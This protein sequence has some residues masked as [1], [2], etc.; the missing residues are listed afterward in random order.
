M[1]RSGEYV[2]VYDVAGPPYAFPIVLLHGTAWT[3]KMWVP[4][5]EALSE[6]FRVIAVDLP[7]H[8]VLRGE[9]F[10]LT[11][12][13]RI[14]MESLRQE[15]KEPG[16]L[17]G[18]SLGG[19]VA[20]GCVQEYAQDIAGLVL[21][22]CSIDYR[23]V[24]GFLS[25]LDSALVTRLFSEQRLTRMQERTLRSKFSERVIAP[26]LA[27]GFS[28]KV[29]PQVYRELGSHDFHT[30]L[31]AYTGPALVLNGE[32]DK[33]NR[34]KETSLLKATQD[35]QIHIIK[36]A[37]HLCNLE[38]PEAFTQQVCTFVERLSA[39]SAR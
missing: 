16:L 26:Q 1:I 18:L 30:F 35:G 29:M 9:P 39:E 21:S 24:I 5:M 13:V 12:A 17:V 4:Q 11:S 33:R 25:R 38:Q 27:A 8:G 23:G 7:G 37:G 14:V 20:M 19:Y 6:A 36:R 28:W 10:Q 22:G 2:S 15:T 3:R 34:V 31:R 32:N